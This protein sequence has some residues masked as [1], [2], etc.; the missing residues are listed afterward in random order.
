MKPIMQ[1]PI[2]VATAIFWNS[3]IKKKVFELHNIYLAAGSLSDR[4]LINLR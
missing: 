1:K 2:A 4:E 3:E